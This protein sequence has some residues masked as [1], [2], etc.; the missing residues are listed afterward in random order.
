MR[1]I[2]EEIEEPVINLTP[3]I[4]VVFV[5]LIVFIV[6]APILERDRIALAFGKEEGQ[7]WVKEGSLAIQVHK[8]NTIWVDKKQIHPDNLL[9]WLQRAKQTN[10]DMHPQL[11]QDRDASFGT[12][13][14]VKNAAELAGF[15]EMDVILQ[16]Q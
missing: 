14:W 9:S 12:Y 10:P 2:A 6:I 8:D 3:L 7:D 16:P 1:R 4:D 15:D 11:Y 5:V 13:Q